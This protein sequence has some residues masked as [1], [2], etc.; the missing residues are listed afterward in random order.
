MAFNIFTGK[1]EDIV[2]TPSSGRSFDIFSGFKKNQDVVSDAV[3]KVASVTPKKSFLSSLF[4]PI[5]HHKTPEQIQQKQ[6]K[7]ALDK[8]A[9]QRIVDDTIKQIN[10]PAPFVSKIKEDISQNAAFINPFRATRAEAPEDTSPEALAQSDIKFEKEHPL[11]RA[12]NILGSSII[13]GA[14]GGQAQPQSVEPRDFTEKAIA[15]IGHGLGGVAA[16]ETIGGKLGAIKTPQALTGFLSKF[17]KVSKYAIPIVEKI[18]ADIPGFVAYGQLDPELKTFSDRLKR[19]VTD[20]GFAG[21][22]GIV[23]PL[24]K[25]ASIPLNGAAFFGLAKLNGATNEDAVAQG[26]IGMFFDAINPRLMPKGSKVG[27]TKNAEVNNLLHD[28]AIENINQFSNTKIN[29]NSTPEEIKTAYREAITKAHPD[30]GGTEQD[31]AMINNSYELLTGKT[32][33]LNPV[34]PKKEPATAQDIT[35]IANQFRP[36]DEPVFKTESSVIRTGSELGKQYDSEGMLARERFNIPNLEKVSFGG[37]DRDVYSVGDNAVVKIAKSSRGLD[38][39]VSS[40]DYYAEDQ[41]LIPK[42][43]EVGKNYLVKEKVSAPDAKT[44]GM[45]SELKKLNTTYLVGKVGG[46]ENSEMERNKA[47]EIMERY[48]YNSN[49]LQNYTPLWGDMV[50]IRNWGTTIDGKPILLDE[51][52]LNGDLVLNKQTPENIREYN[53]M[54]AESRRIKKQEGDTDKKTAYKQGGEDIIPG[55]EAVAKAK[56]MIDR[57]GIKGPEVNLVDNILTGIAKN[58]VPGTAFGSYFDRKIDIAKRVAR[59]TGEHEVIHLVFKDMARIPLFKGSY[60]SEILKELAQKYPNIKTDKELEEKLA[61]DFEEYVREQETGKEG[62][63]SAKIRDFFSKI[64]AALK[65]LLGTTEKEYKKIIDFYQKVYTGGG[66]KVTLKPSGDEMAPKFKEEIIRHEE[67]PEKVFVEKDPITYLADIASSFDE[68]TFTREALLAWKEQLGNAVAELDIYEPGG[69]IV[70]MEDDQGFTQ[71]RRLQAM[72]LNELP[73]SE[74]PIRIVNETLDA[75]RNGEKPESKKAMALYDHMISKYF[76]FLDP[77]YQNEIASLLTV[78]EERQTRTLAD[79]KKDVNFAKKNEAKSMTPSQ[80]RKAVSELLYKGL[81]DKKYTLTEKK[82]FA[83]KVKNLNKGFREGKKVGTEIAT[84]KAKAVLAETRQS[85]ISSLKNTFNTKI[86]AIK[87]KGELDT[88]EEKIKVRDFDRVKG[89]IVS[90]IK[91]NLPVAEQGKFLIS[92]KNAKTQKDLI[93]AFARVD[94]VA[95]KYELRKAISELKKMADKLSESPSV[96][97]DYRNKIKGI[98][99]EYELT[100]HSQKTIDQLQA[101]QDYLDNAREN[102]DEVELPQ[103]VLN[104]LKILSRVSKDELTLDQV[105]GLQNQIELLGSIGR[106]KYETRQNLYDN[107]KDARK[108][109]LLSMATPI[110]SK[111]KPVRAIGETKKN[112]VERYI[113]LRNYLQ[114]S[115]IALKPIDGLAEITGM[116]PMKQDLDLDFGNYLPYNDERF[117]TLDEIITRNDLTQGNVER[118]GV[119]A[120]SQQE[121]GT[122]R[123]VANN[124]IPE[125]AI[126]NLTL[127]EG[128]QELYNYIVAENERGYPIVK[129]LAQDLYNVDVG[130]VKNYVSFH[131]DMD[132]M[133]DLQIYDR[134]GARPEDAMTDQHLKK[135]VEKGFIESRAKFA[136]NPLQLDIAKVFTRHW[137]DVAWMDT[138]ARDVKMYAEI[139]NSP[140]MREKLGDVGTLAWRQWLDLM[141]RKGG[142]EGSHRIKALDTLRKNIGAGILGFRLSSALVQFSSFADTIGTMGAEYATKGARNIATSKEWRNFI[143]DN[144]PEVRKAMGDDLAFREFGDDFFGKMA[145]YGLKPLE[146]LDNLMRSTA[147][148]AAYEKIADERGVEV[149][150]ANP[151]LDIIQEA[152]R[153][154]RFSQGSSFFKDQPLAIT[155]GYGITENRSVNK[156]IFTFQSF[157]LNRWDNIKRQIWRQGIKEKNYSKAFMSLF[158]LIIFSAALEEGIRRGTRKIT[159]LITGDTTDE[160]GFVGS[161]ATNIVQGVPIL[162]QLVSSLTY[163]SNP[164]PV[165]SAFEESLA[166]IKSAITGKS[167]ATKAKGAI[168]AFGGIGSL[169]GIPGSSQAAQLGGKAIKGTQ[170]DPFKEKL[171][172]SIDSAQKKVEELDQDL[173][174]DIQPIYEKVKEAGFG[175][176]EADAIVSDMSDSEYGVYKALKAVDQAK[177]T[178][179]SA[180][181]IKEIVDKVHDVGFGTP[182]GDAIVDD[183]SD[184]EYEQYKKVKSLL[185]KNGEP[186]A[187]IPE[188]EMTSDEAKRNVF[189]LV[190]SYA[191]AY[192]TDPGNAFK[193]MFTKETLGKVQG[194]LVELQRFGSPDSKVQLERSQEYK[195]ELLTKMGIVWSKRGDYKLEH[196]IPVDAGGGSFDPDNLYIAPNDEHNSYTPFDIAVGNAI[197]AN[198]L[199]RREGAKIARQLKVEKSITVDEALN[200]IKE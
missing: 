137:D 156:T 145:N 164:V 124:G 16:I 53:Q 117:A 30:K 162:G 132:S 71:Y 140:E 82:L 185:Y 198:R 139:V 180:E 58:G 176:E 33:N 113:N 163:S 59:Y 24:P 65:K 5:F 157:M 26:A 175:T 192:G 184:A 70:F 114:K 22:S 166:G 4:D 67:T 103:M 84:E 39:N 40:A 94:N 11:Y 135:N 23:S 35:D 13:K 106:A 19:A 194:N 36:A 15:G 193:A 151:D 75:M 66:E 14:T 49:E 133:N 41:G 146:V 170:S 126:K 7:K 95:Q 152:T 161:A 99:D 115:S 121:G 195:K 160:K 119:Y 27:F 1:T 21:A 108:A 134:F 102:G 159:D 2:R 142:V 153:L 187:D 171:N 10:T 178:L 128:E 122:E 61:L 150:L 129:K 111:G 186:I 28:T 179:D 149:D 25:L 45:I 3:D 190:A 143:M 81:K 78:F 107:E 86:E 93:K 54:K 9:R 88:L 181:K 60:K 112:W 154:M 85:I 6:E 188:A 72:G 144:F 200:M 68:G 147:A 182:E 83:E 63:W 20:A 155:A 110:N 120:I 191:K 131:S 43:I 138:M 34:A 97:V 172:N 87:R 74:R 8:E 12:D 32:E 104:K 196:I 158:W 64:Y 141:A 167:R 17:P 127:N 37:S 47:Y 80:T 56:A 18:L 31:A 69:K 29:K 73:A 44:K 76:G 92:V 51:G 46:Y 48:G 199:T 197:K 62:N 38:Q 96:S 100:G 136:N 118:V 125:E 77:E 165:I 189:Q 130:K 50:A 169:F 55:E 57:I 173:V 123:L 105:L 177:E 183:L 90:Y 79:I 148:S 109:T 116:V 101:T 89:E 52:T 98:I 42:T 168:K 91:D 174:K